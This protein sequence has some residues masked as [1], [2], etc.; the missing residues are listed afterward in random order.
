MLKHQKAFQD[1]S[2]SRRNSYYPT[3]ELSYEK[4]N[5]WIDVFEICRRMGR[6]CHPGMKVTARGS[7]RQIY[8]SRVFFTAQSFARWR[9]GLFAGKRE[10]NIAS[11]QRPDV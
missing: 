11:M 3:G 4:T 5:P 2:P 9:H 8:K 7:T 1:R 10:E 6:F